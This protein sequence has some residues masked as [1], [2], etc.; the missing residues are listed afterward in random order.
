MPQ[1][2]RNTGL[3]DFFGPG[4][5]NLEQ[6]FS[7]EAMNTL[8]K[9]GGVRAYWKKAA[10]CPC[11]GQNLGT[12]DPNCQSCLGIGLLW[13]EPQGPF[14]VQI[15]S[16][17]MLESQRSPGV[18]ESPEVG[19]VQEAGFWI[20]IPS[21]QQPM[22]DEINTYDIVIEI[23]AVRKLNYNSRVGKFPIMLN[24]P[25]MA[26]I[27]KVYYYQNSQAVETQDYIFNP[28]NGTLTFPNLTPGTGISVEYF[29]PYSFAAFRHVG[30]AVHVRPFLRGL[31]YP[32]R[33]HSDIFDL[34]LRQNAGKPLLLAGGLQNG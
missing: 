13:S 4:I 28:Q 21:D 16:S 3:P 2:I 12:P 17:I 5:P 9:R 15:A 32:K 11:V 19:V 6:W 25:F 24:Y 20:T 27:D 23:D 14:I 18:S 10:F 30:G 34:F 26:K 1:N 33:I 31:K 29:A 8:I 22:Y 7:P